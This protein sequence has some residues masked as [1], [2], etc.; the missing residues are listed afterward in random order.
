MCLWGVGVL[1]LTGA[2]ETW[3]PAP[4]QSINT[5]YFFFS[6]ASQGNNNKNETKTFA[7][8]NLIWAG[9]NMGQCGGAL[10]RSIYVH[11]PFQTILQAT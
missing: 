10:I 6:V 11:I 1:M 3:Q 7:T 9:V 8:G 5:F 4:D 2:E